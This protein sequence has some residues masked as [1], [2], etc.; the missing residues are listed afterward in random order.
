MATTTTKK[1]TTK[2]PKVARAKV[3]MTKEEDK[4]KKL[5]CSCCGKP[6]AI[7]TTNFYISYSPLCSSRRYTNICKLCM[8][9][10][11][12][13][14]QK[15]HGDNPVVNVF[16]FCQKMDI[17]FT[18]ECYQFCRT[19]I[20]AGKIP[21]WKIYMQKFNS[22]YIAKYGNLETSFD[23][24]EIP[25]EILDLYNLVK[26]TEVGEYINIDYDIDE[27]I[28]SRWGRGYTG[29]D[30]EQLE[31]MYEEWIYSCEGIEHDLNALKNIRTIC[32]AELEILK[33]QRDKNFAQVRTLEK[34]LIDMKKIMGVANYTK[35]PED[36]RV[37]A[38]GVQI[39]KIEKYRPAEYFKDRTLYRDVDGIIDYVKRFF[40]RPMKNLLLGTK[41]FDREYNLGE[42]NTWTEETVDKPTFEVTEDYSDVEDGDK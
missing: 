14:L 21:P 36:S 27:R 16:F 39:A 2:K 10:T 19:E 38:L 20:T 32:K 35:P 12:K 5:I 26:R 28:Y 13:E 15:A 11:Y 4:G 17:K 34:N 41:E 3:E 25:D 24:S 8:D 30:Y 9:D 33:A 37:D 40:L 7:N 1:K 23:Y 42:G 29:E 31:S 22:I 18:E 6:K